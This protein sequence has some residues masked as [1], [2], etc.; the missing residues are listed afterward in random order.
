MKNFSW[1]QIFTFWHKHAF[2]LPLKDPTQYLNRLWADWTIEH[3][4]N[5]L[6]TWNEIRF[7]LNGPRRIRMNTSSNHRRIGNESDRDA[8]AVRCVNV[9]CVDIRFYKMTFFQAVSIDDVL[10]EKRLVYNGVLPLMKW[11]SLYGWESG[12]TPAASACPPTVSYLDGPALSS[13]LC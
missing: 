8:H 13:L 4:R 2:K 12:S 1:L 3:L 5:A 7:G 11:N 6:R 9:C 10:Y